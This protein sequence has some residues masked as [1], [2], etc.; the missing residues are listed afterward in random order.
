MAYVPTPPPPRL[1]TDRPPALV[2][3]SSRWEVAGFVTVL[4]LVYFLAY[5]VFG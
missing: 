4:G 3:P 2:L 5:L 1:V